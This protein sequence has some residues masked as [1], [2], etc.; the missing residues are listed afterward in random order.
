MARSVYSRKFVILAFVIFA[1]ILF[2][3]YKTIL[4]NSKHDLVVNEEIPFDSRKERIKQSV[5]RNDPLIPPPKRTNIIL[6]HG[7]KWWEN[8]LVKKYDPFKNCPV[9]CEIITDVKKSVTADVVIMQAD[10]VTNRKLP[11]KQANQIWVLS[12]YESPHNMK[13]ARRPLVL[14]DVLD[15]YK[16]KFNWTMGYRRDSD[17]VVTHG[18]FVLRDTMD[19]KYLN[20][21][22]LLMKTKKKTSTWFNSHCP[23]LSFREKYGNMLKK[24]TQLDIFGTCGKVLKECNPEVRHRESFGF[25]KDGHG[26][27]MDFIDE[28]YKFF[29][30]F[31]NSLCWDYV[32]EKS[33]Q[34]IMPHYIVPV[35]RTYANHTLFH[36]PGSI[37]D[38]SQFD[39]IESLGNFLSSIE[40]ESYKAFYS[41]RKHY[42]HENL[43]NMWME[44]MCRI[45]ERSYH[46]EKYTRV[47]EDIH[48][49]IWAPNGRPVCK[50]IKDNTDY[51]NLLP[52]GSGSEDEDDFEEPQSNQEN[53]TVS[54]SE[55]L[56]NGKQY[57]SN[58]VGYKFSNSKK[59]EEKCCTPTRAALIFAVTLMCFGVGYMAGFFTPIS[60]KQNR[61][62]TKRLARKTAPWRTK[63][64]DYGTESCIRLVDIDGDGGQD[65]I[66]GLALGKDVSSMV[67]EESMGQFCRSLGMDVPC[68]GAVI[69]LRGTDGK[70]LWKVRSYSE[71]F[72]LNCHTI[73]INKD[74]T[75]DC[76]ATGRLATIQAINP[77]NGEVFWEGSSDFL[78]FGWNIYSPSVIPDLDYDG[79]GE[80]LISH[81]GDPTVP[82][83]IHVRHAGQLLV[84][85]GRTGRPIGRPVWMPNDRET[86][87]SP[88]FHER[89]DGSLYVLY[90]C[91]GETVDGSFLAISLPDLYRYINNLPKDHHVPNLPGKYNQWGSKKPDSNGTI[92][93]FKSKN[94]GVMVPPVLADVTKDGVKDILMSSFD[95]TM[96]LYDGETLNVLW[97][98]KFED[99]ESYSSPSPGH[100]NNDEIIDFM[101]HWSKGAWPFYNTTDTIVLDGK[102]G[103]VLW[104]LTSH[105]YDVT[106]DLTVKTTSWNRDMFMFRVQGRNGEDITHS[107]AIHGATGIQRVINR[108]GLDNEDTLLD[109]DDKEDGLILPESHLKSKRRVIDAN[110]IECETDQTVFTA[111]L[112][113]I[114]R[115]T[116]RNP[117]K[118]WEKGSEKFYYKLTNSD[119]KLVDD[120]KKK[121]GENHTM[122]ENEVPWSR[123]KREAGKPFCILTQPDERT[124]GAFGDV[125]GD[126][127]LDVI[128]NLVSVGVL[129][130][131]YANFVKMKFD[132]DIYKFSLSDALRHGAQTPI[133][134][135]VHRRL[136]YLDN[137]N[138]I[139]T[140]KF[141]SMDKQSWGGY[142][143]TFGD[144][145]F[146]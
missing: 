4:Q 45:C 7:I 35:V 64:S 78:N 13:D 42:I 94:K 129:R 119:R 104:N 106:S 47:Y 30:S 137:E 22:G 113:A 43:N 61:V 55:I 109:G 120:V 57:K 92:E 80:V 105:R 108:R 98:V 63:I 97:T 3:C 81:G 51:K 21:L 93:I 46:R 141:L 85:S 127:E 82:A 5:G 12:E 77:L 23:T 11:I 24:H 44:N 136:K 144:S 17:F 75:K 131:E 49:W 101:V 19:N 73:D 40:E 31:E 59:K 34:R 25:S 84:I 9:R 140:L 48:K 121:Y 53:T 52:L 138:D 99:R 15:Q 29:M 71:V 38:T 27:C 83:E 10:M 125:D 70:L 142:M 86:Y 145:I 2:F 65:I 89:R 133:N 14:K 74:G 96:I 69:A 107:G 56:S 115:T 111:E 39:S 88:I 28:Q 6:F 110:Y 33:L 50:R 143:G 18:R 58:G 100:F 54:F 116:L 67:T 114:D 26:R 79:V 117:I 103:A 122:T 8:S 118:L 20:R 132:T 95:G 41:W 72:A 128:V 62:D 76:I 130:D 66:I 16:R 87:F 123:G 112:F 126:G 90:G 36:P 68:A 139:R 37:V 102:D 1:I 32:T 91:G 60:I 135:T 134:A 146:S 124:T